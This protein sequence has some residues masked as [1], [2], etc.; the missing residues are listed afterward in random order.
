MIV[1]VRTKSGFDFVEIPE[2]IKED[3]H[4]DIELPFPVDYVPTLHTVLRWGK[5]K[6]FKIVFA[7][8]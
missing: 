1:K 3:Y 2:I 8:V 4:N 7:E 6:G 5:F